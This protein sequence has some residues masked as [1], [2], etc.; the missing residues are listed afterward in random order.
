MVV[1]PVLDLSN[2]TAYDLKS[3]RLLE[4]AIHMISE[5]LF[6]SFLVEPPCTTF[7]PAAFPMVRSYQIP[8]GF[9]RT[10]TKTLEGNILA[11]RS[12]VLLKVGRC[13]SRPCGAEQPRG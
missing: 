5:G 4:W 10:C 6:A 8:L 7:S 2:S 12:F 9:D 13:F 3:L 1:A 11:F